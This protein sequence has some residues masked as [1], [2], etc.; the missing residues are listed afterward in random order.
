MNSKIFFVCYLVFLWVSAF[1]QEGW[2]YPDGSPFD[3][4]KIDRYFDIDTADWRE[5]DT[6]LPNAESMDTTN[7]VVTLKFISGN[8]LPDAI[9][10]RVFYGNSWSDEK[11]DEEKTMTNWIPFQEKMKVDLGEGDGERL[12]YAIA[13]W[14]TKNAKSGLIRT[15]SGFGV[16]VV[17]RGPRQNT[18]SKPPSTTVELVNLGK[19]GN[20]YSE[21]FLETNEITLNSSMPAYG[22]F[23]LHI[24]NTFGHEFIL[25]GS[26]NLINWNPILTNFDTT[27][28]SAFD[29]VDTNAAHYT[30]RFFQV[31]PLQ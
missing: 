9:A 6:G 5:F 30:S 17:G 23:K 27:A 29:F 21:A 28:N 13:K 20:V 16:R 7:T 11:V 2:H 4:K 31:R 14:N 22:I 8:Q 10:I 24:N 12:V 1:A 19:R 25:Y 18:E 3:A 26:T 15:G